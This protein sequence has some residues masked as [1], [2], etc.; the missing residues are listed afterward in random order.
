MLDTVQREDFGREDP[1]LPEDR[2]KL[3]G[4]WE[5]EG[6]LE[7]LWADVG[8]ALG[9]EVLDRAPWPLLPEPAAEREEFYRTRL[10]EVM[11]E[12]E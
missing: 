7:R 2:E 6:E 9:T 5:Q 11:G 4:A 10:L 12:G 3:E 1:L 8:K